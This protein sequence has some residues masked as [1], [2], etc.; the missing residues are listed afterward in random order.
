MLPVMNTRDRSEFPDVPTEIFET[1]LQSLTEEGISDDVV[2]ELRKKL[3][4]E[5]DLTERALRSAVLQEESLS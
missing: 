2:T 3:I 4:E 1:F 5:P